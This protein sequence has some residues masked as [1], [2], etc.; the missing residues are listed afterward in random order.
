MQ[1]LTIRR[2]LTMLVAALNHAVEERR[3]KRGD[4]PAIP[5]PP[6][7]PAHIRWLNDAE[8]ARLFAAAAEI[9]AERGRLSKIERW[10]HV[11]YYTACRKAAMQEL[12]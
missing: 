3:L 2:D 9:S 6:E 7:N 11:S 5:F 1:N 4:V 8:L 10:L 12:A